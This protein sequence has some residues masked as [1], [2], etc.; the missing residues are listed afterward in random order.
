MAHSASVRRLFVVGALASAFL[1]NGCAHE[2][3]GV[4]PS[5]GVPNFG[6]VNSSLMRGAQPDE[7][8]I[9]NLKRLRVATIINLRLA[10]DVWAGEAAAARR[11]GIG[12]VNV[13]LRGLRA[14]TD[15]QV[16]QVLSLL[17]AS[18]PPVFVHCEH[19]A[20]RT[21]TIVACYRM[22]HDGWT[23]ER[24]LAEARHYGMSVWQVGMKRYVQDYLPDASGR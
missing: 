24:A 12:Y 10:D 2:T 9:E 7:R 8:G 5:E 18:P 19:G 15:A 3:R 4:P 6:C 13:P 21:G 16:A 17:E 11:H 14:P 23:A 22:R 20:D 1:F